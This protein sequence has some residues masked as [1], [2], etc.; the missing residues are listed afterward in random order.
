MQTSIDAAASR[1]VP[2][3]GGVV[4]SAVGCGAAS[5]AAGA[6]SSASMR[7][8]SLIRR[9]RSAAR[10]PGSRSGWCRR[11]SLRYARRTSSVEALRATPSTRY[12]S[13][14]PPSGRMSSAAAAVYP[15]DVGQRAVVT[16]QHRGSGGSGAGRAEV[17]LYAAPSGRPETARAYAEATCRAGVAFINTTSDAIARNPVWTRRFEAAGL[18]LLGGDLASQFGASVVHNALLRL[19]EERGLTRVSSYQVNLGA[20]KTSATWPKTPTPRGGPSSTRCRRL[21]RCSSPRPGICRT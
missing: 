11:A 14:A 10:G 7:Y 9:N 16:D 4:G 6:G 21:T 12:G 17:Q 19:L 18:P 13:M 8:A 3:T 20:P 1:F 15:Y 5:E 2:A